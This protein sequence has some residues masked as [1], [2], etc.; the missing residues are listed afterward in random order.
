MWFFKNGEKLHLSEVKDKLNIIKQ[1]MWC[2]KLSYKPELRIYV[3]IK[4]T[5]ETEPFLKRDI[6]GS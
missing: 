2:K 3:Q 1:S 5:I 4:D 6:S